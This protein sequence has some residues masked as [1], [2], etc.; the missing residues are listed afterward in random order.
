MQTVTHALLYS[1]STLIMTHCL[2]PFIK[3]SDRNEDT[4]EVDKSDQEKEEH[5][6]QIMEQIL[7]KY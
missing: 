4:P 3:P 1:H 6:E 5:E 2:R 7:E